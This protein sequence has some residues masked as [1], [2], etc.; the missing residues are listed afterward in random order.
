LAR[1]GLSYG[2]H[3]YLLRRAALGVL[4]AARL[5]EAVIPVDE[6]LPCMYMDHPRADLR[7]HFPHRL[8]ALAFVPPIVGDPPGGDSDV[9]WTP[10]IEQ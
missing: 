10:F 8:R 3:A 9:Y 5:E 7:A 6:F 1:P 2:T 4:L